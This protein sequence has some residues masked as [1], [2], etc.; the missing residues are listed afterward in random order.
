M[1]DSNEGVPSRN[2]YGLLALRRC[3]I[4][5]AA[6]FA[7]VCSLGWLDTV[8]DPVCNANANGPLALLRKITQGL[9]VVR[10]DDSVSERICV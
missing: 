1:K 8:V 4:A 10:D 6:I 5:C 3:Y 2:S 9:I 7:L